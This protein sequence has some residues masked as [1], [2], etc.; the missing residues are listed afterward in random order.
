MADGGMEALRAEVAP[1]GIHTTIVNPGFFRTEL[2]TRESTNYAEP[3]IDDY[4]DR[5]ASSEGGGRPKTAS[6]PAIPPSSPRRC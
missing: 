1:L 4:A 6:S 3:T 2:L 5:T